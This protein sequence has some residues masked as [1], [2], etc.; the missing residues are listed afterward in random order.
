MGEEKKSIYLYKIPGLG[1]SGKYSTYCWNIFMLS[2]NV[3]VDVMI[4]VFVDLN[5]VTKLFDP[6]FQTSKK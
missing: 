1:K 5:L 6:E 4:Q 3:L 2:S